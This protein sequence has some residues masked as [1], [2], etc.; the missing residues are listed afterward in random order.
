LR[1]EKK[2]MDLMSEEQKAEFKVSMDMILNPN[3]PPSVVD[4]SFDLSPR[5][6]PSRD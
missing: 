2:V 4:G 6:V 1:I 3:M 5:I